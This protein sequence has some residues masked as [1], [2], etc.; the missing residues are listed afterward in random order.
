MQWFR[1]GQHGDYLQP[2]AGGGMGYAVPAA[3][4]AKLAHPNRV[5]VAVCGDGGFGMSLHGLMTAVQENLAIAVV[6]LNNRALG[7]VAH[8]LG[9]RAIAS[10]FSDFDHAA[11]A[12]AIGCDGVRIDDP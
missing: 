11:I 5:V 1:T 4:A 2:A 7:W 3:L 10:H 6:V 8:G 9:R 12:R